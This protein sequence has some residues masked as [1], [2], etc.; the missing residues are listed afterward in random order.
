MSYVICSIARGCGGGFKILSYR[1][2]CL[3]TFSWYYD[4]YKQ[5]PTL[6]ESF[7]TREKYIVELDINIKGLP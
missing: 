7:S 5:S 1:A 2:T 6:Y 4:K 3:F